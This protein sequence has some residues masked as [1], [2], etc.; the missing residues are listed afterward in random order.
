MTS[1]HVNSTARPLISTTLCAVVIATTA[2]FAGTDAKSVL[3][4]EPAPDKSRCTWLQKKPGTLY[5]NDDNPYVQR[6]QVF[7]RF[8]WQYAY[9]DGEGAHEGGSRN[10]NY[11]T[12]EIRRLRLGA[13]IKFL[14]YFTAQ[15]SAN[16]ENDLSPLGGDRDIEYFDLYSA[17]LDLDLQKAFDLKSFDKLEISTGKQKTSNSAEHYISSRY[18]KTVERSS[19]SNYVTAPSST[20]ISLHSA[21]NDWDLKLGICSGDLEKEFS[22]FDN[23]YFYTLRA[24]YKF[25]DPNF[26]DKARI[27]LRLVVNGDE[28]K[29]AIKNTDSIGSFNQKWV[30]SLS[31]K[32]RWGKLELLTD[33][34]YGDNGS[35]YDIDNKGRPTTN[36][37]REGD[38]WGI[39][40]M[41]SYWLIED[42]LETVF[43]YQYAAASEKEGFR[44]SGRYSRIAGNVSDFSGFNDMSNGRGDSHHSAYLGFNYYLCGNNAK[45]MVGVEYDDLDSGSQDVYEGISTWAAFRMYF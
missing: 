22:K 6:L 40:V 20:G 9:V 35:D 16:F 2:S 13:K 8:Q 30:A 24:G 4:K 33:L 19:L 1:R 7:G 5:K 23:D 34:I 14:N 10:F 26:A 27:N 12:E 18:I 39:V 11:D 31:T 36:P 15:A 3:E 41:P 38:F 37:E 29:N 17:T 21:I 45:V 44:I 43:R 42:R 25:D 32:S 28:E